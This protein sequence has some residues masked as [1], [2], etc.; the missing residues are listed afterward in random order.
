MR[1]IRRRISIARLLPPGP[2][3]DILQ[4][5]VHA[6]EL[7]MRGRMRAAILV[8]FFVLVSKHGPVNAHRDDPYLRLR[9]AQEIAPMVEAEEVPR[10]NLK[11]RFSTSAH[12]DPKVVDRHAI[13]EAGA[14]ERVR[15]LAEDQRDRSIQVFSERVC[16]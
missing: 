3:H 13:F 6:V 4:V 7:H 5:R 8:P 9:N 11:N 14:L 2:A 16:L 15:F 1:H 12:C 10:R